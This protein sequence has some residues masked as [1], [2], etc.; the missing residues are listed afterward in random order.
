MIVSQLLKHIEQEI[1]RKR[2]DLDIWLENSYAGREHLRYYGEND[3]SYPLWGIIE[4]LVGSV[5]DCYL[6]NI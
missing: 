2:K 6:P 3:A 5:F 4:S 1:S